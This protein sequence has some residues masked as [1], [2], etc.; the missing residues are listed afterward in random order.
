MKKEDTGRDSKDNDASLSLQNKKNQNKNG[1][2]NG[3][4]AD[5]GNS[6]KGDKI[7]KGNK[8]DTAPQN[9]KQTI[10]PNKAPPKISTIKKE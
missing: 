1:D 10:P 3:D 9:S 6:D 7:D 2:Q 4:K 5:K 8:S